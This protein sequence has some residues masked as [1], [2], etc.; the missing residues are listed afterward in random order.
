M[1]KKKY[2]QITCTLLL[3]VVVV[4]CVCIWINYRPRP[5]IRHDS[6]EIYENKMDKKKS[7]CCKSLFC[8]D[9]IPPQKQKTRMEGPVHFCIAAGKVEIVKEFEPLVKTLVLHA[10]RTD[11]VLHILTGNDSNNEIK[12]ILNAIPYIPVKFKYELIPLNTDIILNET[13]KINLKITHHSEIWG[14]SKLYMYE[15][16]NNVDKCIVLDTDIVFGTDPAFLWELFMDQEDQQMI[17][18]RITNDMTESYMFNSRLMLQDFSRMRQMTFSKFYFAAVKWLC[19]KVA[20]CSDKEVLFSLFK[21]NGSYLFRTLPVSWNLELC[22]DFFG[23]SFE[24][25]TDSQRRFF[26]GAHFNC[27]GAGNKALELFTASDSARNLRDYVKYLINV[28]MQ[29]VCSVM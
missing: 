11:M 29:D 19:R 28:P 13:L 8:R 24:T 23:F 4:V 12:K 14:M 20:V 5:N 21:N 22:H 25:Y 7:T 15:I 2:R 3:S 1:A 9:N 16:F 17:S 6:S 26:G 18:M 27:A 10:K